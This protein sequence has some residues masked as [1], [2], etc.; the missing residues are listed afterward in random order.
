MFR[1]AN[2]IRGQR[3]TPLGN[4]HRFIRV[5]PRPQPHALMRLALQMQHR[6][7]VPFVAGVRESAA[8]CEEGEARGSGDEVLDESA[9]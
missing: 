5:D 1:I 6:V 8:A 4:R 7:G 2:I 3:R 9:G